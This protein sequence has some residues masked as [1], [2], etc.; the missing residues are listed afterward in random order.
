MRRDGLA[1][2]SRSVFTTH[3]SLAHLFRRR[4]EPRLE[5][6]VEIGDV[7]EARGGGDVAHLAPPASRFAQQPMRRRELAV[8]NES[9][10]GGAGAL[11]QALDV[12]RRQPVAAGDQLEP[13]IGAPDLPQDVALDGIE[14]RRP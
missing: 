11:E 9:R 7:G 12:A 2:R 3:Y 4:A 6:A 5:G 8:E 13:E 1:A 14:A 10:K